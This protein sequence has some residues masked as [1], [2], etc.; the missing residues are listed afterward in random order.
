MQISKYIPWV[1]LILVGVLSASLFRSCTDDKYVRLTEE[2]NLLKAMTDIEKLALTEEIDNREKYVTLIEKENEI[3][4]ETRIRDERRSSLLLAEIDVLKAAEP[5]QPELESEPLVVNLRE[6]IY[7]LELAVVAKE[8]IIRGNDKLIFNLKQ[9]YSSQLVISENYKKLLDNEVLLHMKCLERV[10]Y[11][12]GKVTRLNV[13]AK[14]KT[15][16]IVIGVGAIAYLLLG[17]N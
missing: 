4:I 1:L 11:L 7:K 13:G 6:Q 9:T 2:Y 8:A 15:G 5:I 10:D 17:G 12:E 3:L 14:F 16:V